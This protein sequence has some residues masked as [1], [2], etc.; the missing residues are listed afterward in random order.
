MGYSNYTRPMGGWGPSLFMDYSNNAITQIRTINEIGV[1]LTRYDNVGRELSYGLETD[2]SRNFLGDVLKIIRQRTGFP[3]RSSFCH[4]AESNNRTWSY[5][6]NLNA[7]ITYRPTS[8]HP[9]M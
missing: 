4:C 3:Q 8:V 1:S 5:S 7:F 9:P 2:F 6:G